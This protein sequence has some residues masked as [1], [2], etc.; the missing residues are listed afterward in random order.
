MHVVGV[1]GVFTNDAGQVLLVRTDKYGWELPGGRVE[2]GEDLLGALQR[3]AR[4]EAGAEVT[5]GP[6]VGV[7]AHVARN[8]LMLIFSG[9][10]ATPTPRPAVEDEV[11][12]AAWFSR[13]EA[14]KRVTH[15]REHQAL[16]DALAGSP[17][18]VY[19]AYPG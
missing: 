3:E 11:R 10:S 8:L 17:N 1:A 9:S 12:D 2:S 15:V 6:L 13:A 7:Y 18:V 5:V 19:R 16:A 4:E 14:L